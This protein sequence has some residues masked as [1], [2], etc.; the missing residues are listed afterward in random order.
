MEEQ[1]RPLSP[2]ELVGLGQSLF[3]DNIAG[4]TPWQTMKSKL[5]V[6]MRRY[7]EA[8]PFVR[9][10]PGR[11]SLRSLLDG[12][13]QPYQ[14]QPIRPPKSQEKVVVFETAALDKVTTWQG[15]QTNW[16]KPARHIFDKLIPFYLQR[17]DIEQDDS[18]VQLLTYV[19]VRHGDS[20]LA[21]RR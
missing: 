1:R 15:L 16:K 12:T 21:Y 17:Y 13:E 11:F 10:G 5:S 20:L 2:K 14:A 6:H 3:S 4:R 7:G 19:L 8:S 18:Y 9:T